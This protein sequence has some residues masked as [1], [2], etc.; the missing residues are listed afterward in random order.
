MSPKSIGEAWPRGH[1]GFSA[2]PSLQASLF[3]AATLSTSGAAYWLYPPA[4]LSIC[5]NQVPSSRR[6]FSREV[7]GIGSVLLRLKCL[8]MRVSDLTLQQIRPL[9]RCLL[10]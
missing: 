3:V 8:S 7:R 10:L 5:D 4:A 9:T 6:A 1:W 2:Q